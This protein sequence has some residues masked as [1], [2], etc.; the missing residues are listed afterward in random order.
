MLTKTIFA[1]CKIILD[2]TLIV[3]NLEMKNKI[4]TLPP[5]GKALRTPVNDRAVS[6]SFYV[7]FVLSL[8]TNCLFLSV[9]VIPV[10]K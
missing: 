3:N 4:S 9:L 6:L 8:I 5:L 10:A 7:T 2:G 1:Q